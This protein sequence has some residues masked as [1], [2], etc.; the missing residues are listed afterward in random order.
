MNLFVVD[1]DGN[2][3][4]EHQLHG[5]RVAQLHCGFD[6]QVNALIGG[7]DSIEVYRIVDGRVPRAH[8]RHL[9]N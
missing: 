6:D 7:R 2:P 5:C 1:V 9:V 8:R 4:A 3:L